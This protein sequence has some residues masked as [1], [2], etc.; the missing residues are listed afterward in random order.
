MGDVILEDGFALVLIGLGKIGWVMSAFKT[1]FVA[2]LRLNH[3]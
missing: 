3:T 1:L 2:I